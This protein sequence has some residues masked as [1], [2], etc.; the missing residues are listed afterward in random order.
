MTN[1]IK[2]SD[3]LAYLSG[4]LRSEKSEKAFEVLNKILLRL[5]NLD[6][7]AIRKFLQEEGIKAKMF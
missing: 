7:P 2:L 1:F 6:A 4:Q 5:E 3:D